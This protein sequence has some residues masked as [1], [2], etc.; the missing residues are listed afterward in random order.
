MALA[1][2]VENTTLSATPMTHTT[3][4]KKIVGCI[5]SIREGE[6]EPWRVYDYFSGESENNNFSV[7]YLERWPTNNDQIIVTHD[8]TTGA[9]IKFLIFYIAP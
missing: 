7:K 1:M 8:I 2:K 3:T 5:V 9:L 4:I 6:N